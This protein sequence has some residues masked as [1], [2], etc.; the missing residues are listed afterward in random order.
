MNQR[1]G[2]PK[3]GAKFVSGPGGICIC[4]RC[5]T[6]KVRSKNRP[7]TEEICPECGAKMIMET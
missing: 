1:K 2:E 7:C 5:E 3:K 4:P 6:S